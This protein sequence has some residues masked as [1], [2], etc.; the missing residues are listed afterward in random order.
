MKNGMMESDDPE[1]GTISKH[2]LDVETIGIVFE[3][4]STLDVNTNVHVFLS[5]IELRQNERRNRCR[6]WIDEDRG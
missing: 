4:E 2:G 3:C 6:C 1:T 5:N